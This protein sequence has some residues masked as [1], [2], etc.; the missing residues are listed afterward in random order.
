VG[1]LQ[2]GA[3][4][5]AFQ[6]GHGSADLGLFAAFLLQAQPLLFGSNSLLFV[7]EEALVFEPQPF[8][9]SCGLTLHFCA[10][11]FGPSL[12]GMGTG[13]CIG[14][15]LVC[16]LSVEYKLMLGLFG[17]LSALLLGLQKPAEFSHLL[18][19]FCVSGKRFIEEIGDLA[20]WHDLSASGQRPIVFCSA[21]LR[22]QVNVAAVVE[23]APAVLLGADLAGVAGRLPLTDAEKRS[24]VFN[25]NIDICL[26][27]CHDD[28]V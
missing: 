16:F 27:M 28:R 15:S 12:G 25:R 13:I 1:L 23:N 19:E 26:V 18:V 11:Q 5:I 24:D 14:E 20:G 8:G 3:K 2:F 17:E 4:S 6:F 7:L 10:Q 21:L 9:I 22:E